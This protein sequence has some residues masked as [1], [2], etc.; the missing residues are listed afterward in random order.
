MKPYAL[1]VSLFVAITTVQAAT[2]AVITT[3]TIRPDVL[4]SSNAASSTRAPDKI[5]LLAGDHQRRG[6]SA[7]L[8]NENTGIKVCKS[9][10]CSSSVLDHYRRLFGNGSGPGVIPPKDGGTPQLPPVV[11]QKPKPGEP[12]AELPEPSSWALTL[13]GIL[14]AGVVRR[15]NRNSL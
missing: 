14:L 4:R 12:V 13:A 1:P 3:D 10:Q 5:D 15:R 11:G 7:H 9:G 8:W 6:G 2:A